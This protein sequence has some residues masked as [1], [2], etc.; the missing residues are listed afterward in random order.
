MY[1]S[2]RGQIPESNQVFF[3]V[4]FWFALPAAQRAIL[5]SLCLLLYDLSDATLTQPPSRHARLY[6][7]YI[8]YSSRTHLRDTAT[9]TRV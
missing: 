8:L 5:F 7:S 2:T 6:S 4:L 1:L 3:S 9:H